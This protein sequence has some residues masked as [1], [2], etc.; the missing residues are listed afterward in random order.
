VRALANRPSREH[1]TRCAHGANGNRVAES[2]TGLTRSFDHDS[3]G[4][5]RRVTV[6]G[7]EVRYTV[8]GS[9]RRIARQENGTTT[10]QWL[11]RDGLRMAAELD[12]TGALRWRFV[13]ATG[14]HVPHAAIGADGTVYR[15]VTD[16]VGSLRL[17]VRA[18]DGAVMQRMRHDAWGRV[19]ENFVEAGFA[20]VPFGFAGGLV[21]QVTGLVHFGAREYNPVVGSWVENDPI[22]WAGGA[23]GL[24]EYVGNSPVG[25]VD[26]SGLVI[27][28][29]YRHVDI[30]GLGAL[31][32]MGI[33]HGFLAVEDDVL[34]VSTCVTD[35]GIPI[36][37]SLCGDF[38]QGV[39]PDAVCEDLS[40]TRYDRECLM[41]A[42]RG[43]TPAFWG[44]WFPSRTCNTYVSDLLS[45]C[46]R[47]PYAG[48]DRDITEDGAGRP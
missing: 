35:G 46:D 9:G 25:R 26:P 42:G 13:Y 5:L 39:D 40:D 12:G 11:Y 3:R 36:P 19:E 20:R 32:W 34:Q 21:D 22:R 48:A 16:Q 23:T 44:V 47:A 29:C 8:D 2:T 38:G 4:T 31:E 6:G 27:R 33:R 41:R 18:S 1:G 15:L 37:L 43:W 14:K 45:R 24:Y 10:A 30:P 7:T 17:V 28:S